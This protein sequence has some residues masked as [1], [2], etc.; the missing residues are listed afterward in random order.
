MQSGSRAASG[1][2][3]TPAVHRAEDAGPQVQDEGGEGT[4][5]PEGENLPMFTCAH[6]NV[7]PQ[8]LLLQITGYSSRKPT[9]KFLD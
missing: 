7:Q 2:P 3:W 4:K 9:R 5:H 6:R 1:A 8:V